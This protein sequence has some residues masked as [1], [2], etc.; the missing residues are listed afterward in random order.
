PSAA[1]ALQVL[2]EATQRFDLAILDMHM[3]G[4]N[5]VELAEAICSDLPE[6]ADM[7][8]VVLSSVGSAIPVADLSRLRIAAWLKKPVRHLELVHCIATVM[9]VRLDATHLRGDAHL[10]APTTLCTRV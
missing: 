5:G 1:S 3:P 9:G 6:R 2:R 8:L 10:P 7:K 4:M